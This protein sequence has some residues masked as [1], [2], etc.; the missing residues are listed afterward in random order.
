MGFLKIVRFRLVILGTGLGFAGAPFRPKPRFE[1]A[2]GVH[3]ATGA[4]RE[5]VSASPRP[6]DLKSLDK[7]LST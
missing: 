4:E 7:V 3:D 5:S 2:G 6:R 1:P